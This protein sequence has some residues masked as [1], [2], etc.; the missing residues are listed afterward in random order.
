[1]DALGYNRSRSSSDTMRTVIDTLLTE[2]E[3]IEANT[4]KE[5]RFLPSSWQ[6]DHWSKSI[7]TYWQKRQSCTRALILKM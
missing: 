4:D 1:M 3:G 6:I 2:I 5:R 7:M